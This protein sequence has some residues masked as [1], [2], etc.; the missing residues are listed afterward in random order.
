[1]LPLEASDHSQE[2]PIEFTGKGEGDSGSLMLHVPGKYQ[3][4]LP[5][6]KLSP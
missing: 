6:A 4:E 3:A 2:Q 5:I 1:V